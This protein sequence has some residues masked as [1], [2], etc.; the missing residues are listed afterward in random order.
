MLQL[1]QSYLEPLAHRLVDGYFECR[2]QGI[3]KSDNA[4]SMKAIEARSL[5]EIRDDRKD[6]H[7]RR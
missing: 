4:E 5:N 6:V 3:C 7:I 2:L 1:M